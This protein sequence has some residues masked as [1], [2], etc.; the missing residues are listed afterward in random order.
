MAPAKMKLKVSYNGFL[1]TFPKLAQILGV[2]RGVIYDRWRKN[3]SPKRITAHL[4]RAVEVP[5]SKMNE[6]NSTKNFKVGTW[7]AKN[8]S[9][10]GNN[11]FGGFDATEERSMI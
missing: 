5:N 9:G 3:G 6:V 7:E 1:Y 2:P 10:A 4:L 11:G 8:L